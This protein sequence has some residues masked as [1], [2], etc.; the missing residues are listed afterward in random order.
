MRLKDNLVVEG[1][2]AI[3]HMQKALFEMNVQLSNVLSD[4]TGESGLRIIEAILAGERDPEQLASLCSVRIK[5]TR[6][7][8]AKSPHGNWDE[9]LLF[10]LKTALETYRF[11]ENKI[12]D[13]DKCIER[14]LA[15][16]EIRKT[17]PNATRNLRTQLHQVC[18]AAQVRDRLSHESEQWMRS[19]R[20]S[21]RLLG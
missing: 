1:T 4:I 19:T 20:C 15:T 21:Q 6:Q 7:T 18:G 8:V 16:F 2:Q 3:H 11:S 10:C 14:Q 17:L 13:C 12:Q 5:A 9:A